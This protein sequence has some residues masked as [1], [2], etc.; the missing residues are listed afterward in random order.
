ML[1]LAQEAVGGD[2]VVGRALGDAA[3]IDEVR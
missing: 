2:H 3:G 1:D